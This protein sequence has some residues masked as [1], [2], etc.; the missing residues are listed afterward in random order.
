MKGTLVKYGLI[1][2]FI[3]GFGFMISIPLSGDPPNY[4][5]MEILGYASILIA[6]VAIFFGI[7]SYRDRQLGGSIQFVKGL[8][9]GIGISAIASAIL[10]LYTFI[11]IA[12]I[13]PE[14]GQNYSAWEID[15]IE[16][17][18]MS[19]VEKE[20]AITSI[21]E[22]LPALDSPIIQGLIMYGTVFVIGIIVSLISAAILK[23]DGENE[24]RGDIAPAT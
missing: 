16:A 12:W 24:E 7:K 8:L 9:T 2:G 13:D 18:E 3:M 19:A 21:K 10:G 15:K 11:H 1:G 6:L 5:T 23:R 14:F 20:E 4:D 22:L 17:S